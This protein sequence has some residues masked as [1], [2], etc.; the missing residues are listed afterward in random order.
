MRITIP[1]RDELPAYA[2]EAATELT[3]KVGFV[4]ELHRALALSPAVLTGFRAMQKA[5]MDMLDLR[6]RMRIA[7]A[8]SAANGCD[9]CVRAHSYAALNHAHIAPGDIQLARQGLA[10]DKKDAAA[11]TFSLEVLKSSGHVS[12]GA[13]QAIKAAGF[14]DPELVEIITLVSQ[15]TFTNLI[16][17]ALAT[18]PDFPSLS[19]PSVEEERAV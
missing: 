12:N 6:T 18:E 1:T 10:T 14:A 8:I 19:P 11:I 16:N 4:P 17:N 15:F 13:V 7:I 3:A 9:Y 2:H 5:T